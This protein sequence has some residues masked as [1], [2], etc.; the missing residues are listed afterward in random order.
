[1]VEVKVVLSLLNLILFYFILARKIIVFLSNIFY[2][3]RSK[4]PVVSDRCE[5]SLLTK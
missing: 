2:S 1:M 4:K 5:V 3:Y